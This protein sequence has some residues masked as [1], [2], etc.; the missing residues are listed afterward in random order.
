[1]V[2]SHPAS[3]QLNSGSLARGKRS[4]VP[5][6]ES[7]T[8][9]LFEDH[10]GAGLLLPPLTAHASGEIVDDALVQMNCGKWRSSKAH[11]YFSKLAN[12][13]AR[14]PTLDGMVDALSAPLDRPLRAVEPGR[15]L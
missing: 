11:E 13:I 14:A 1:M 5:Q 7:T 6:P 8:K 4:S 9:E 2:F 10:A 3:L 12:V 15:L